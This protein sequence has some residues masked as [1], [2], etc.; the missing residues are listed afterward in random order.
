M[1]KDML[2]KRLTSLMAAAL[3]LS[4]STNGV[5]AQEVYFRFQPTK[6]FDRINSDLN[7]SKPIGQGGLSL[8]Y[9][10]S[11]IVYYMNEDIV[12]NLVVTGTSGNV[13][14][15]LSGS[16]S[17]PV[18]Y[19]IGGISPSGSGLSNPSIDP[20]TGLFSASPSSLGSWSVAVS[21]ANST[22]Q[23][24]SSIGIKAV[25][26]ANT[27]S[28]A[29][30]PGG[31][32]TFTE[33]AQSSWTPQVNNAQTGA[34]WTFGGNTYSIN[35]ALPA[36]VS[37]DTLTGSLSGTPSVSGTFSGYKI[38]VAAANGKT[39]Q[40]SAFS[41]QINPEQTLAFAD[42]S[43]AF[44]FPVSTASNVSLE[45]VFASGSVAYQTVSSTNGLS[46]AYDN[47]NA[48]MTV[49]ADAAG[50][51]ALTVKATDS[52]NRT[53]TKTF[54]F[55]VSN[56]AVSM[57]NA[58]WTVGSTTTLAAPSVTGAV[59][60]VTYSFQGLPTGLTANPQS[61]VLTATADPAIGIYPVTVSVVDAYNNATASGSFNLAVA[62]SAA[63]D[64]AS[65]SDKTGTTYVGDNYVYD[66]SLINQ[67]GSYTYDVY[68]V[69]TTGIVNYV[70]SSANHN[71]TVTALTTG[72]VA[73][74]VSAT[75]QAGRSTPTKIL[76]TTVK[77]KDTPQIAD[78]SGN[79]LTFTV[80]TAGTF[81]PS[82]TDK[83]TSAAWSET[84][85]V[86]SLNQALPSG[87]TLDAATGKISGTTSVTGVYS[88]YQMTVTS[89]YG[90]TTTTAPFS[91]YSVPSQAIAF[92]AATTTY[93]VH[94]GID[95]VIPIAVSNAVGQVTYS[96]VTATSG[97][98][99]TYDNAN[100]QMTVTGSAIG[101]Y[102]LKVQATDE[103]G[104]NVTK[105]F[106]INDAAL[107]VSMGAQA[108]TIGTSSTSTLPSVSNALGT[109]SYS[110]S[111][112]PAGLTG[113][114][115]TG[116]I[117]G[118]TTAASGNYT[119][120]LTI[121]DA[122]DNSTATTTFN[123][124]ISSNSV[125]GQRCWKLT[126]T[127]DSTK[128]DY[129]KLFEFDLIDKNLGNIWAT[130]KYAAYNT[131]ELARTYG[132]WSGRSFMSTDNNVTT[133]FNFDSAKA[134]YFQI[135]F[136]TDPTMYPDVSSV[137]LVIGA[138]LSGTNTSTA[139]TNVKVWSAT[140]CNSDGTS[141][142]GWTARFADPSAFSFTTSNTYN[143]TLALP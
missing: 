87:L 51:Y 97:L 3:C 14:P 109:V 139:L 78:V 43:S 143:T 23:A 16:S 41:I 88:G 31:I 126:Y 123:V 67:V 17:D 50:T 37:L 74:Y 56:L 27:P 71:L 79:G 53:A 138:H 55:V 120:T 100:H 63:L 130:S 12:G 131:T 96:T 62:P 52:S 113:S 15:H 57:T 75:D 95:T 124:A 137:T 46:V 68:H 33:G 99:V 134:M 135:D 112:L 86:F 61:G 39:T 106:T 82:V 83:Q 6:S 20:S 18:T 115:S 142:S 116:Q 127:V 13:S 45:T 19:S 81:T 35:K 101:T 76:T 69:S 80:G 70:T 40:S 108:F 92:S 107:S 32:I 25:W 129:N 141:T 42:Q 93:T 26:D 122:G 103:A 133:S 21:A 7:S 114:S 36:G 60:S 73:L 2:K 77:T 11:S 105:T 1:K 94:S 10:P 54:S 125:S 66:L 58:T 128:S 44:Q 4:V 34:S 110:Y 89:S 140:S 90:Q 59:G 136:G 72:Q 48:S 29:A 38:S 85:T 22:S 64:F 5:F 24:S 28:I 84:G 98:N 117:S 111:N 121:T 119:A 118:N 65:Y 47:A 49:S 132:A 9:N 104:R 102:T 8:S 30:V 91:I